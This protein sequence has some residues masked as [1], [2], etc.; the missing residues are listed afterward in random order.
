M[1]RSSVKVRRH[2]DEQVKTTVSDMEI[3]PDA[4]TAFSR[5]N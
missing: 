1:P 2:V 5:K 3:I 4:D